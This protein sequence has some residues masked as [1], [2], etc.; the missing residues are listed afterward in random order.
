[1]RKTIRT[2]LGLAVS[3][4]LFSAL[5]TAQP[6]G[7]KADQNKNEEHHSRLK[8]WQRHNTSKKKTKAQAQSKQFQARK[9]QMKPTSAK[10]AAP[11]TDSKKDVK[12]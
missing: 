7:S 10:Q 2:V 5:A 11:K 8:F 12:P 6:S 3:V 1:M 9:T 4:V